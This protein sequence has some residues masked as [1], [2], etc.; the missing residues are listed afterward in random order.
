LKNHPV[1]I[2]QVT[3]GVTGSNLLNEDIRNAVS[4]TKD[5]VLMPGASV[6]A[7]ANVKF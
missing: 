3:V 5:A 1:G 4:F 7:F 2:R 6:R